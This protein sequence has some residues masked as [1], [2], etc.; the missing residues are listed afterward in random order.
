MEFIHDLTK[1]ENW[2]LARCIVGYEPSAHHLKQCRDEVVSLTR[3]A[4]GLSFRDRRYAIQSAVGHEQMSGLEAVDTE[5]GFDGDLA[6]V[7][8][9]LDVLAQGRAWYLIHARELEKLPPVTWLVEGEIPEQSIAVLYAAPGIGKSFIA[10]DR[11]LT[12]AQEDVVV[13][14][15]S[16]GESGFRGR[17]AAWCKHHKKTPGK[18]HFVMGTVSIME[19]DDLRAFIAALRPLSPR[20]VVID[21]LADSM[22]GADENS[23]RD[24][25]NYIENCKAV[26][27][28]LGCALLLIHHTNKTGIQ[29]RGNIRIRA[30]ADAVMRLTE[31]DDVLCLEA[32]KFKDARLAPMSYWRRLP[33]A[34]ERDGQTVDEAVIVPSSAVVDTADSVLTNKQIK[35]LDALNGSLTLSLSDLEAITEIRRGEVQKIMAR[36]RKIGLLEQDGPGQPYRITEAGQR[37]LTAALSDSLTP[38]T[39]VT[40]AGLADDDGPESAE[41]EES[42]SQLRMAVFDQVP[43]RQKL[44]YGENR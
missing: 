8:A 19:T 1:L 27:R 40:P 14:V 31:T 21:T 43:R 36:L 39:P 44:N 37:A 13:Y 26:K 4:S 11:A 3:Y 29:E 35:V 25:G 16:E 41:S 2:V 20:L 34:V 15:A 38:V 18:L 6:D 33:V 9:G 32:Q 5:S 10:L 17:V 30:S 22:L 24:V 7:P 23:T 42:R 28:A 12:L